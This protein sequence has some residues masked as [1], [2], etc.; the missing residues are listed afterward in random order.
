MYDRDNEILWYGTKNR[1][2]A[3]NKRTL[4]TGAGVQW[5]R[6]NEDGHLEELFCGESTAQGI[7]NA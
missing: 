2:L 1:N 6:T 4:C 7:E 3:D 5:D